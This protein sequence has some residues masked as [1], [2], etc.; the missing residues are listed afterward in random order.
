MPFVYDNSSWKLIDDEEP[1]DEERFFVVKK[2]HI[3]PTKHFVVRIENDAKSVHIVQPIY[4]CFYSFSFVARVF[5][6]SNSSM[7]SKIR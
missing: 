1:Y 5:G 4:M 7:R 6:G 3:V 2:L